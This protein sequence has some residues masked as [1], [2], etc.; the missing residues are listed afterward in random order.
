MIIAT[1]DIGNSAAKG[2]LF[3]DGELV[4]I[5][6]EPI[7]DGAAAVSDRIVQMLT[8]AGV[9]RIGISS[10]VPALSHQLD[11]GL[12][13]AGLLD[14]HHVGTR[15]RLPFSISYETPSTLGVDRI[16][17]VAG[18]LVVP[19]LRIA[20]ETPVVVIDAG[21]AATIDVLVSGRFVG[22]PILAGPELLRRAVGTGTAQLPEAD[23]A[24]PDR[25]IAR[26]TAEAVTAGIMMGFVDAVRGMLLRVVDELGAQPVV[27]ATGGWA[28]LL[29]H[30]VALI[31]HHAPH[32]VLRGV[33]RIVEL[34]PPDPSG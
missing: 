1:L 26:G 23:L 18:A 3:D 11:S 32:L 5:F 15:S 19:D 17:A 13:A 29:S 31:G 16:A 28:E 4:A 2:G 24:W 22:G 12:R 6:R 9:D 20:A 25:A 34:N 27:L 21:T 30:K 14:V 7:A 33:A 10:V 8:A